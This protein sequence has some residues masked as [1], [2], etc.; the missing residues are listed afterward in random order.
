MSQGCWL[1]GLQTVGN[2]PCCDITR[3]FKVM[4][5]MS[6]CDNMFSGLYHVTV[7][8]IPGTDNFLIPTWRDSF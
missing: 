5:L 4:L 8:D 6:T 2:A 1:S 3:T 7:K